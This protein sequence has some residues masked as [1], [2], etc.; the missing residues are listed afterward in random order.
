MDC[1]EKKGELF[2][3]EWVLLGDTRNDY[4]IRI[5]CDIC[6]HDYIHGFGE[7]DLTYFRLDDEL[8]LVKIINESNKTFKYLSEMYSRV[9]K[10]HSALKKHLGRTEP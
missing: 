7:E 2:A 4:Q 6:L 3:P 1:V 8:L 10:E 5:L 9:L